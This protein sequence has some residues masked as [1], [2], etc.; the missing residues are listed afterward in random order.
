MHSF[1]LT[2]CFGDFR[3]ATV[4]VWSG[5]S[6]KGEGVSPSDFL[7]PVRGMEWGGGGF[8]FLGFFLRAGA[9]RL[10]A[11]EGSGAR[12]DDCFRWDVCSRVA[13]RVKGVEGA[14]GDEWYIVLS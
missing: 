6:W 10:G 13:H 9:V 14:G 7:L 4:A 2:F 5:S 8:L 1:A 12:R 11:K 3:A